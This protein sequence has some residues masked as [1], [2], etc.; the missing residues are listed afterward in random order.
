MIPVNELSMNNIL[1]TGGGGFIGLALVREL[2]RQGREVRV[3]GRRRYPAA[4]AAG[5]V[6]VQGDLRDAEAVRQAAAGCSSVFHVA[7]KAGIWGSYD[8]YHGINVIGTRNV[9][10]ACAA[11][12]VPI[13]VYTSTPSVVFAGRDLEGGDET[14]PYA[15]Q[16]LCHYAATK[17]LAEQDVL[18]A[19]SG[20]MRTAAIRPHLVW[21]PGDTNLIPRLLARGR[22]RNLR[23]V[24]DGQ[25]RVDIAYIDNVVHAHLLAEENLRGSGTAAGKAFFIGQQEPV[26]LWP[27]INELFVRMN[28]PPVTKQISL[29]KAK[30]VG[31]LLEKVYAA[32]K[33][34][35]EPKMTRFLAEQ[36]AMSHWFSKKQAETLLGYQ[37]QVSTHEGLERLTAWLR[38]EGL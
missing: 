11:Q 16:P 7:A 6:C 24:G 14:L 5:A 3:F 10:A 25:N 23:V 36:L 9:L 31:W 19:N 12:S 20:R 34:E 17:I 8:E 15:A 30:A 13:L 37:E 21:G 18:Q 26:R 27:W 33:I 2:R 29:K 32:L 22:A 4:E 1:V 38:E 28:V 35:R